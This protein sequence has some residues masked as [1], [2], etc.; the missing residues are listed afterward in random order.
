MKEQI[1]N[2]IHSSHTKKAIKEKS[3]IDITDE[4]TNDDTLNDVLPYE[5]INN[6]LINDVS[7]ND[8]SLNELEQKETI[9]IQSCD[10]DLSIELDD[11]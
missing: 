3:Y 4:F 7:F 2:Y 8:N 9:K 5:P 1:K 10:M 6:N 11:V